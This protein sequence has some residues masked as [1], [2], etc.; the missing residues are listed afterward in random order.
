MLHLTY[1]LRSREEEVETRRP[2]LMRNEVSRIAVI[3]E[4]KEKGQE[5]V[6]IDFVTLGM[7]IIGK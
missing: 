3:M 4:G 5:P 7:F 1:W 6:D 2:V